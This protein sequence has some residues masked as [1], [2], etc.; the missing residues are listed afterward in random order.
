M[1]RDGLPARSPLARAL[2]SGTFVC[3][4]TGSGKSDL[5]MRFADDMLGKGV[6]VYVIDP[7]RAWMKQSSVPHFITVT[8]PSQAF[9]PEESTIFDVA[10]M[11]VLEQEEIVESFCK[12]LFM[13]RVGR[14]KYPP[15]WIVLEEAQT[16]LPQ[17][18]LRAK[19]FQE[20][21]RVLSVGR[22]FN[23]KFCLV[24][25]FASQVDK[26]AVKLCGQKYLGY[27]SEPN[28]VDYL[29]GYI[30]KE[31]AEELK[32]LKAGQFI[33]E[34]RGYVETIYSEAYQASNP[35][36]M[37]SPPMVQTWTDDGPRSPINWP[38]IVW[39]VILVILFLII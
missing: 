20:A 15:T 25:P 14:T 13:N 38:I 12:A 11:T 33:R 10:L 9:V 39:A 28:D 37:I 4:M 30:G 7:A 26:Y 16:Y 32:R 17:G 24:T 22:N 27:T 29:D 1:K 35:P 36:K 3:G 6:I 19:R 18:A 8:H 23:I 5:A 34:H 21:V 31:R 2:R